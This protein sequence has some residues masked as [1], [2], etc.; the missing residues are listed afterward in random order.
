MQILRLPCVHGR[1]VDLDHLPFIRHAEINMTEIW[2]VDGL[3]ILISGIEW[4][5]LGAIIVF[6]IRTLRG[7]ATSS[8][9]AN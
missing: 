3:Y 1:A 4:F 8:R 5:M 6:A 9:F 7:Q 2:I